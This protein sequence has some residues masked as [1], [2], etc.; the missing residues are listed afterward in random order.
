MQPDDARHVRLVGG[1]AALRPGDERDALRAL[2][3][4]EHGVEPLSLARLVEEDLELLLIGDVQRLD[5]FARPAHLRDDPAAGLLG[6]LLGDALPALE[7]LFGRVRACDA[8]LGEEEDDLARAGLDAFLDDII[9]PVALGQAAEH[10]HGD[11]GLG[12]AGDDLDHLGLDLVGLGADEAALIVRAL[13][14]ADDQVLARTQAQHAHVF[15]VAA[16]DDRHAALEVRSGHKKS[17]HFSKASV[18]K[19]W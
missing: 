1:E 14:V 3:R 6:G 9:H 19:L 18:F 15:G 2:V 4:L 13:R 5:V 11:G 16:A 7:L 10:R 17:R 12:G 8:A